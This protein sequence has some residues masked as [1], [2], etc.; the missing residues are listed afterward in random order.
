[1]I[2]H[3]LK[4]VWNRKRANALIIL[5]IFISFLVLVAVLTMA[6][7]ESLYQQ[8]PI[9]VGGGL[10]P[11]EKFTSMVDSWMYWK[12]ELSQAEFQAPGLSPA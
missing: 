6:G 3:L 4:L 9:V 8:N 11:I 12:D 5:E 1:M 7:W 2:R 10:F